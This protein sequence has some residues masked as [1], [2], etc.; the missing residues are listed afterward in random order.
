M[1]EDVNSF[2]EC[3]SKELVLHCVA[4][5]GVFDG[6]NTLSVV[7]G[8]IKWAFLYPFTVILT[9]IIDFL[10]ES[11]KRVLFHYILISLLFL[12]FL[13]A[14]LLFLCLLFSFFLFLQLILLNLINVF[15][16]VP[17]SPAC[18][19]CVFFIIINVIV[20]LNQLCVLS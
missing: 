20:E 4:F 14:F 18:S 10:S 7:Q 6:G 13:L 17:Q 16:Q 9:E 2:I 11:V 19:F 15:F 3:P 8:L 5:V 1:D 12:L